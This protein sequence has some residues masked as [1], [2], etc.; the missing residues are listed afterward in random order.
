M[1]QKRDNKA[2][3]SSDNLRNRLFGQQEAGTGKPDRGPQAS[4]D[5]SSASSAG[6]RGADRSIATIG[7]TMSVKGDLAGK[8][9]VVVKGKVEGSVT[10]DD[11]D[12]VVDESG[13]LEGRVIARHVL[14]KGEVN[15][16]LQGLDKVTIAASGCVQGTIAA[17]RVVLEDGGKF[18]GM[19]DMPLDR[20]GSA[21]QPQKSTDRNPAAPK[22]V[23]VAGPA[24]D[25]AAS[26]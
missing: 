6:R 15:G 11:N 23:A 16:E 24:A 17:P 20:K 1:I 14:I 22:R 21:T 10:L 13:Q 8:E 25:A 3:I 9:D 19:I 12:V 4:T 2:P 26:S 5:S 7:A 18:K